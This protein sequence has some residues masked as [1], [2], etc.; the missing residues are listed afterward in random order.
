MNQLSQLRQAFQEEKRAPLVVIFYSFVFSLLMIFYS[1]LGLE[2]FEEKLEASPN[3][4]F[5]VGSPES[6]LL[7]T[8]I[9][10]LI[11]TAIVFIISLF[12]LYRA[13]QK[14]KKTA[15][16]KKDERE[17]LHEYQITQAGYMTA[18]IGICF[19]VVVNPTYGY[20]DAFAGA[21]YDFDLVILLIIIVIVR[22]R[23]RIM[24]TKED[25]TE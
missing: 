22:I 3:L 9:W 4:D 15:L 10:W 19:I 16:I 8:A 6:I 25:A 5:A 7:G 12:S 21:F 13:L 17:M 1:Y 14:D 2:G 18:L 23:K 11:L 24:L 20:E